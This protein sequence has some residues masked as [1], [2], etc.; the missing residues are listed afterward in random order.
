MSCIRR[1]ATSKA[2]LLRSLRANN[3]KFSK[4]KTIK[5]A[6]KHTVGLYSIKLKKK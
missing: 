6:G 4:V 3:V 2:S 1:K 5:K